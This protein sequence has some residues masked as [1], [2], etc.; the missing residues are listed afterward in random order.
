MRTLTVALVATLALLA[1]CVDAG[2]GMI[3]ESR[4]ER[5]SDEQES[6]EPDGPPVPPPGP[7]SRP[8]RDPTPRATPPPT[9]TP[10]VAG[11]PITAPAT[12]VTTPLATPSPATPASPPAPTPASPPA[13]TPASPT[14]PATPTP[15]TTPA[16]PPATPAPRPWPTEGSYVRLVVDGPEGRAYLNWT[17][18]DDDW[19]GTCERAGLPTTTYHEDSP[20]HW[21]LFNTRDVPP[22]GEDVEVWWVEDCMILH[23]Q[24]MYLGESEGTHYAER[25]GFL[26][27][28]DV[29]TG[30]V[31]FWQQ[32]DD[33]GTRVG[34]LYATDAP[35]GSA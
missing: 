12:P 5:G 25:S 31:R 16:A 27:R 19:V 30:L 28:W 33:D 15:A 29:A 34:Q 32:T 14:P 10:P 3:E 11:T 35:L 24:A 26:T 18:L 4:R 6:T 13:P 23:G 8:P 7:T 22:I 2:I 21:P 1:G 9:T 20:P 17:Y